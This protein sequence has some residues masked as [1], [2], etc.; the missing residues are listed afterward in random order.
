[1]VGC[2]KYKDGKQENK[3]VAEGRKENKINADRKE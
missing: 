1:M 3:K 2:N